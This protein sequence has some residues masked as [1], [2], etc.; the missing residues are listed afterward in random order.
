[1][2]EYNGWSS[3]AT[4]NIVLW[5]TNDERAYNAARAR[6]GAFEQPLSKGDARHNVQ[7]ALG[8]M[9]PDGVKTSD[10][11]I[12]WEEIL[13]TLNELSPNPENGSGVVS[14]AAQPQKGSNT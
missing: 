3:R 1:M 4:W 12:S 2:S 6:I 8:H 9:T 14:S 13:E 11:T 5:L 10:P 7:F